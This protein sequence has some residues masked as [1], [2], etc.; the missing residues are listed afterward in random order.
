MTYQPMADSEPSSSDSWSAGTS[1]LV[2]LVPQTADP[3]SV[4]ARQIL[5]EVR[6]ALEHDMEAASAGVARLAALLGGKASQTICM[7]PAKGGLAPW[8]QRKVRAH[9]EEH[10]DGSILIE[11]LAKIA[12]L[13]LSHFCRAFKE[14]FGETPHGFV[15]RMRVKRAQE[16]MLTTG[17][18]LSQI[19]I[20]CG[21]ADQAHLSR[22]F[23]RGTGQTPSLWRRANAAGACR[24]RITPGREALASAH[25]ADRHAA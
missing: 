20:A 18:P 12:A 8:Q 10:L 7:A 2:S 5:D 11:S 4:E 3:R 14:S 9:I 19:A 17:E 16:L 15:T 25:C 1:M 24:A 13:S 23:R 6:L 21:F 22:L